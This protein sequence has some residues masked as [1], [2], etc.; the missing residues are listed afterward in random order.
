MHLIC[1]SC[2]WTTV[3]WPTY[4]LPSYS[5][6]TNFPSVYL[7]SFSKESSK[8]S[9][10]AAFSPILEHFQHPF[11]CSKS[12]LWDMCRNNSNFCTGSL[13]NMMATLDVCWGFLWL[14]EQMGEAS[15]R[16]YQYPILQ[17]SW[18]SHSRRDCKSLPLSTWMSAICLTAPQHH[19]VLLCHVAFPS[20]SSLDVW[21]PF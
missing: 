7:S 15:C 13:L 12:I 18:I 6:M 5:T 10:V 8:S 4:G 14:V 9:G 16:K 19:P 2:L 21:I 20:N 11:F 1:I 17:S 3:I